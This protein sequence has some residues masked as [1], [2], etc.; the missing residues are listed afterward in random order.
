MATII[1][2][3]LLLLLLVLLLLLLTDFSNCYLPLGLMSYWFLWNVVQSLDHGQDSCLLLENLW[4]TDVSKLVQGLLHTFSS[5]IWH[6]NCR[7]TENGDSYNA[8]TC[9]SQMKT[10]FTS[11]APFF[12]FSHKISQ[13]CWSVHL[14]CIFG[15]VSVVTKPQNAVL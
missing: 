1:T 12:Y 9:I 6:C 5:K 4:S 2:V 8:D 13:N 11:A 3:L 7:N 10:H 15:K 14:A